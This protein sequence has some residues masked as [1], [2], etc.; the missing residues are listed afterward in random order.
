MAII[1][2]TI[3]VVVFGQVLPQSYCTGHNKV[4]IGYYFSGFV[5]ALEC[6]LY[7]FVRPIVYILDNWIGHHDEK[8]SLNPDNMK[9]ILYLHNSRE[10]G[11]RAEEI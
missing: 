6:L 3:A 7:I 4:K 8:V 2:S 5:K 1:I 10:Y 11:Y 9:A